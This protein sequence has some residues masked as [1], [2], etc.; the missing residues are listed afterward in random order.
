MTDGL[1]A[2]HRRWMKS[3]FAVATVLALATGAAIAAAKYHGNTS[4]MIF[5]QSS[6]RYYNCKNCTM[7]FNTREAAIA[8]G[9]RPCK[10]CKP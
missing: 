10:V 8:A 3:L 4:S 9:Y 5:H 1:A 7:D 6:C 2:S